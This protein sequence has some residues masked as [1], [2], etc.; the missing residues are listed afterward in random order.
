M[1]MLTGSIARS[2]DY[3]L[4]GRTVR[5]QITDRVQELGALLRERGLA[6]P[7]STRNPGSPHVE[8]IASLVSS[9]AA[10]FGMTNGRPSRGRVALY[11]LVKEL[12]FCEASVVK[13]SFAR[14][15]SNIRSQKLDHAMESLLN[16]ADALRS[17]G[18][19]VPLNGDVPSFSLISSIVDVPAVKL[20]NPALPYRSF[21]LA[22]ADEI[23]VV[24]HDI[25][26]RTLEG[27]R[28]DNATSA[29]V[30]RLADY[31]THS[32]VQADRPLPESSRVPG[33]PPYR[34]LCSAA[35]VSWKSNSR[36][37]ELRTLIDRT[38]LLVGVGLDRYRQKATS[39][40]PTYEEMIE[41][42]GQWFALESGSKS[43]QSVAR[44]RW[45][46]RHLL[47]EWG[48]TEADRLHEDF[49]RRCRDEARN[50]AERIENRDTRRHWLREIERWQAYVGRVIDSQG[51]QLPDTLGGA[52]QALLRASPFKN[53]VELAR[54]ANVLEHIDAIRGWIA[55]DR[56]SFR[57][58]TSV[59]ERLEVALGVEV[60][61]LTGRLRRIVRP[62]RGHIRSEFWPPSL[63]SNV[64]RKAARPFLPL[65]FAYMPEGQREEF[66]RQIRLEWEGQLEHRQKL[67]DAE[68]W[69]LH[70]FPSGL[71]EEIAELVDFKTTS[72]P[73]HPRRK[74]WK[75]GTVDRSI[76][77]LRELFSAMTLSP[78]DGGLG[79]NPEQLC[80]AHLI[81]PQVVRWYSRW[82]AQR[83]PKGLNLGARVNL[84]LLGS[85]TAREKKVRVHIEPVKG[86]LHYKSAL[87]ERLRA[88]EGLLTSVE[89]T[90]MQTPEGWALAV[91]AANSQVW[92]IFLGQNE[93]FAPTRDPFEPILPILESDRPLDALYTMLELAY[94]DLP[95][96]E[97]TPATTRAIAVRSFVLALIAVRTA[98]RRK[99]LGEI[100]YRADNRGKL[101][102]DGGV[103]KIEIPAHEFK[104]EDGSFFGVRKAKYSCSLEPEDNEIINEYV[105][106]SRKVLGDYKDWLF[107]SNGGS[108]RT[109]DLLYQEFQ[110]LT[111]RYLVHHQVT[112]TGIMGVER[113]GL[114]A[115]RDITA[116]HILKM[117]ADVGL[118][119]DALQDTQEM[120]L[121]HYAHYLPDDRTKRVRRFFSA[122]LPRAAWG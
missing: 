37:D 118:A 35:G 64:L 82:L 119:A 67:R 54:S 92:Q 11:D 4:R 116:T 23:G 60:G 6:V 94:H 13:S 90:D 99:N 65:N 49:V 86:Y 72:V 121:R 101:K 58:E 56:N 14:S 50:I 103:W 89:V 114:H 115:V 77:T 12:G 112:G 78:K 71:K 38:G 111:W 47:R 85:L 9:N 83:Y 52:V 70:P 63:D 18:G 40:L 36:D 25:A 102:F 98:L 100:T 97:S 24:D 44:L 39:D 29:R 51:T 32:F 73:E 107:V 19:R 69:Q 20:A 93:R 31:L 15:P 75:A 96:R 48:A 22:L 16:W 79:L 120:I 21:L 17:S 46:L 81:S 59:V 76:A 74:P 45:A 95:D 10:S 5:A 108:R 110:E 2:A 57:T 109:D 41:L 55:Q 3:G 80:L 105:M 113:F 27:S 53:I 106:V 91:S 66:G 8:L 122:D 104:N 87:A 62:T 42:G 43:S 34:A 84:A 30:R 26:R 61:T 28:A 33:K 1:D 88:V 7:E 117:T 68:H